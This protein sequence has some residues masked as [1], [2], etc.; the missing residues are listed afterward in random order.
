VPRESRIIAVD[1]KPVSHIRIIYNHLSIYGARIKTASLG[2]VCTDPEF[3]GRG[4][5]T[6]LLDSCIDEATRAGAK[7][8]IISGDR[9]LY[10]RAQAA[11][12]G[13]VWETRIVRREH[14]DSEQA[15]TVRAAGPD[16]APA[17]SRLHQA[18]PVRYLR[19]GDF[20][21]RML[22]HGH[23]QP[24]LIES[25]ANGRPE[26]AARRAV[27][28]SDFP[29]GSG[30]AGTRGRRCRL[31]FGGTP[32]FASSPIRVLRSRPERGDSESGRQVIAYL[33]LSRIWSLPSAAPIRAL[34]EYGGSRSALIDGMNRV[35]EAA[36]LSEIRISFPAHDIEMIHLLRSRSVSLSPDTIHSHTFRLLDLPGLLRALRPYF[37]ARLPAA[38][39]RAFSMTP[40]GERLSPAGERVSPAGERV[41]MQFGSEQADLSLSE[42]AAI[43]FGGPAAPA[44]GGDLG[45]VMRRVFPV[46]LPL[47]GFNYV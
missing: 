20:F 8:L 13:P 22:R 38:A 27:I 31:Q 46:P 35:M 4:I 34:G 47:P 40:S 23:R 43:M 44:I 36:G 3:R 24:W 16:D 19:S 21:A 45:E 32:G 7:L 25:D 12:A 1:G 2:G 6:R 33:S 11:I 5:A 15:L 26:R 28:P 18:E 9:G 41:N 17:L 29:R 37:A 30:E 39:L 10:L 14:G 42:A